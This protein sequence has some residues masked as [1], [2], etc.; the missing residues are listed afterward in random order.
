MLFSSSIFSAAEAAHVSFTP[1][2]ITLTLSPGESVS[3][4]FT[5]TLTNAT[6]GDS[7]YFNLALTGGTAGAWFARGPSVGLSG[8]YVSSNSSL[9]VKVPEGVDGGSYSAIFDAAFNTRS[10]AV[11]TADRLV[12][13]IQVPVVNVCSAVPTFNNLSNQQATI[14]PRNNK[15]Y[16]VSITGQLAMDDNCSLQDAWYQLTDEYG[17]LDAKQPLS[18]DK[19]GNF[20]TSIE[21]LASRKGNDKDGRKYTVVF[22]AENEAGIGESQAT[23]IIVSHDNGKK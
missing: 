3:I 21:I 14:T 16:A 12:V 20:S 11:P 4:P 10:A 1:G 5:A 23:S 2:Q 13:N 15:P 17:E 7:A 22:S 18:I 19:D 6:R 8:P 9:S